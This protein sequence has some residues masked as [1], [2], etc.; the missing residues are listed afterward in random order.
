MNEQ[1]KA[2]ELTVTGNVTGVGFRQWAQREAT[3]LGVGGW[4]RNN[5]D[6]TVS[7]E[8]EG[9]PEQ[10]AT[11]IELVRRGPEP[12]MV[13]DVRESDTEAHGYSAFSIE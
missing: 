10:V 4:V 9:P 12:E 8:V 1:V 2:V 3:R 7:M 5:V 13:E 6:Q 11:F